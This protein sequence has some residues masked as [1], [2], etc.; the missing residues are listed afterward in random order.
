[1]TGTTGHIPRRLIDV[2]GEVGGRMMEDAAENRREER[3]MQVGKM[4][5]MEDRQAATWDCQHGEVLA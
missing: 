3:K 4:K 5:I 1:M 2:K